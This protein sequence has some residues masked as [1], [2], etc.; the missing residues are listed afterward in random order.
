VAHPFDR[1]REIVLGDTEFVSRPGELYRPVCVAFKELRSGLTGRLADYELGPL[2]P[3]A[4]GPDVLFVGFTGAEP[5]LYQSIGWPFDTDFLDLRVVGIQ[6][7]NFAYR[8]GD[9]QRQ[10]LPRSLIQFLRAND[11]KDGDEALKDALRERI[12][13]GPPY[14]SEEYEQFKRYCFGDVLLLE[15]LLD[16]LL[17]RIGNFAQALLFGEFVKF[18]A[19]A[20]AKPAKGEGEDPL[21]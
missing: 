6:Q 21:R 16:V 5:E 11:I 9:P 3:H 4:H 2:P 18:T 14:T 13:H 10:K 7:T 20:P 19:G 17:P 8:R 1:Y 15:R 12:M